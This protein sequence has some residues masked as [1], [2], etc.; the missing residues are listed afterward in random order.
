MS[1]MGSLNRMIFI[2]YAFTVGCFLAG[3]EQVF[4]PVYDVSDDLQIH[5]DSFLEESAIR[6]HEYTIS[7]LIMEHDPELPISSCGTCNSDSELSN[8]QKVIKINP[9]CIITYNEQMEALVFH[10]L[11]HCFLGRQH[12]YG[13]LPNGDPKSI[14]IPDNFNV[15]APCGY[16]FGQEECNF[17]FKR[18]YYLDEFFDESTPVPSWAK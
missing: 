7:N 5:V 18:D 11:G 12:D 8:I 1:K 6:G 15:Y 3:C 10:E 16:Q 17:T 4:E 13:L 2:L 14:M 9:N